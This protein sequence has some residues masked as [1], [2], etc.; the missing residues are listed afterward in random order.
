MLV[1]SQRKVFP[2]EQR[3]QNEVSNNKTHKKDAN[4]QSPTTSKRK[5]GHSGHYVLFKELRPKYVLE[6]TKVQ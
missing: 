1:P 4:T 6:G 5:E 3:D 2:N